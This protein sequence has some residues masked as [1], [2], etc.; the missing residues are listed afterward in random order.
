MHADK[1][2]RGMSVYESVGGHGYVIKAREWRTQQVSG[3]H[4]QGSAFT[5]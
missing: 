1:R 5:F 4:G 3:P 2:E